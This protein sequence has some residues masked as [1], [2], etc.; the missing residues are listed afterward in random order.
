MT[1]V[2]SADGQ[3]FPGHTGVRERWLEYSEQ[4]A[5]SLDVGSVVVPVLRLLITERSP[6]KEQ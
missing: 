3:N 2:R 1:A 4:S 6:A 5:V